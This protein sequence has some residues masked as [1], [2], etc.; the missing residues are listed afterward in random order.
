MKKVYAALAMGALV[1]ASAFAGVATRSEKAVQPDF[2][3]RQNMVISAD[4]RASN[5]NMEKAP[6]KS[7][8]SRED[9]CQLYRYHSLNAIE[10]AEAGWASLEITPGQ[11]ANTVVLTG[12]LWGFPVTGTFDAQAGTITLEEQPVFYNTYYNE[13]VNLYPMKW[14]EAG[15]GVVDAASFV[16]TYRADGMAEAQA[17]LEVG[18]LAGCVLSDLYDILHYTTPSLK[19]QGK[20]FGWYYLNILQPMSMYFA[21]TDIN[22][23]YN[24]SEWKDCGTAQYEDGFMGCHIGVYTT[25]AY[26]VSVKQNTNNS[27]EVM[28]YQPYGATSPYG[29]TNVGDGNGYIVFNVSNPDCVVVRPLVYSGYQTDENVGEGKIYLSN[30]AG[31]NYYLNGASFQDIIDE[32]EYYGDELATM[33][34]DGVVTIPDGLYAPVYDVLAYSQWMTNDGSAIPM[35]SVIHLP[36]EALAG[37][38]GIIMDTE[39]T[40]NIFFNLQGVRINNPEKGQIVIVKNGNNARK[41]VL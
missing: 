24:A 4:M 28:L 20:G 32:A 1:S 35:R 39:K 19:P 23:T 8:I 13:Y 2:S 18:D 26:S 34:M 37:V 6:A 21:K 29:E 30:Y 31:V 27:S 14:N 17:G 3:H 7:P 11:T 5:R 12:L 10:G 22:F 16:F 15:D 9:L 33:T 40:N 36:E 38:E 41:V 25:P